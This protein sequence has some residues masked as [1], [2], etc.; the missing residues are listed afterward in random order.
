MALSN[1]QHDFLNFLEQY[2]FEHGGLPT[3]DYL[4]ELGMDTNDLWANFSKSN[5]RDALL[6]RGISLAGL[7]FHASD[8][9]AKRLTEEQLTVA[10]VM[11]DL[12]DNRSQK[13]KLQE[14]GVPTA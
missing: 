9:R 5:F 2:W 7:E 3:K 1:A 4:T 12:R 11:L 13:K 10:N 8:P 6:S 14:L